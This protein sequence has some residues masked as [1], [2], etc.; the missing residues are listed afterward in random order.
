M[1]ESVDTGAQL[2]DFWT[3]RNGIYK[4][5]FDHESQPLY[6]LTQFKNTRIN[7]LEVFF[8]YDEKWHPEKDEYENY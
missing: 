3:G 6:F 4:S 5:V 7:G 8:I 2:F 1:M